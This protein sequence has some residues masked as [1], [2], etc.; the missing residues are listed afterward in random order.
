MI[1]PI[2][3]NSK[4]RG[5]G[6][7]RCLQV[8]T[9]CHS[10]LSSSLE[11]LIVIITIKVPSTF[12]PSL[13]IIVAIIAMIKALILHLNSTPCHWPPFTILSMLHILRNQ[14]NRQSVTMPKNIMTWLFLQRPQVVSLT[15]VAP[16]YQGR[17]IKVFL[18]LCPLFL[19]MELSFCCLKVSIKPLPLP[20]QASMYKIFFEIMFF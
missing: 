18:C 6:Q 14:L 3:V 1:F 15:R 13:I 16:Y 20:L 7:S 4:Q 8:T 9:L 12:S 5:A 11:I 2:W 19:F 10:T 17:K